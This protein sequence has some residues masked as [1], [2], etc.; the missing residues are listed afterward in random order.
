MKTAAMAEAWADWA[1]HRREKRTPLTPTAVKKQM[2]ALQEM[3]HDRA[4]E[5][6]IHSTQQGYT[7]VFE[8]GANNSGPRVGISRVKPPPGKYDDL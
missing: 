8:P 5:A 7:G 3:G 4:L 6:L 2:K 1:R